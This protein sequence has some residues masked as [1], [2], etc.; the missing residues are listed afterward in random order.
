MTG[1]GQQNPLGVES[2]RL[3]LPSYNVDLSGELSRKIPH[4]LSGHRES[5]SSE[6]VK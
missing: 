2:R 4:I 6:T 5:T 1:T 3:R